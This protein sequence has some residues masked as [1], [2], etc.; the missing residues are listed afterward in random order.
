MVS[1]SRQQLQLGSAVCVLPE[2][3]QSH[4]SEPCPAAV[5]SCLYMYAPCHLVITMVYCCC[6]YLETAIGDAQAVICATGATGFGSNSAASVD[7]KVSQQTR[8]ACFALGER[9]YE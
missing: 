2:P 9:H 5:F 4:L 7:E 1:T 8:L 3:P 6:S